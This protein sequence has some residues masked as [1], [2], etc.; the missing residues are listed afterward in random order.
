[1]CLPLGFLKFWVGFSSILVLGLGVAMIVFDV[2]YS[3]QYLK[4]IMDLSEDLN[5]SAFKFVKYGPIILGSFL[6]II[7]LCGLI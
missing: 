5:S 3:N 2:L 7:G 4:N 1:M 6:S